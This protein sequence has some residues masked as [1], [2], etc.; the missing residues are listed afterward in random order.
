[1]TAR[2]LRLT[3]AE[4]LK[5]RS[6]PFFA[7]SLGLLALAT[8]LGALLS[9]AETSG[10]WSSPNAIGIFAGGANWGLCLATFVA[11]IFGSMLFAGEFDRGTI[12]VLLTR[13]ITRTDLFLAKAIV[14]VLLSLFLIALVLYVS[15]LLGMALG[16]LGPVWDSRSY[17]VSAS[18]E[19]LLSHM[20]T[21]VAMSLAPIV[22]AAF[23]GIF[24]SN[25]VDSSGFSVAVTLTIFILAHV[26]ILTTIR[27]DQV[28]RWFFSHYP[29]YGFDMLQRVA[30]GANETFKDVFLT[31]SRPEPQSRGTAPW[32][33]APY[34]LVPLGTALI[35]ASVGYVLFRRK[36]ITV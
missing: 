16:E 25:V 1:M 32:Y 31:F 4:I 3:R 29:G 24:I 20:R 7:I 15:L 13:P 36:N 2:I 26:V 17:N 11:L 28:K 23:L 18:Y 10:R 14:A 8:V 12:K 5:L 27:D 9:D 22:A 6:Q 21:A 33:G 35:F 30:A 19:G 34:V